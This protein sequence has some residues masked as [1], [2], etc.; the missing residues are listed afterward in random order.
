[1]PETVEFET[2]AGIVPSGGYSAGSRK[3]DQA[4]YQEYL[5]PLVANTI[6]GNMIRAAQV[7]LGTELGSPRIA[8]WGYEPDLYGGDLYTHQIPDGGKWMP[9]ITGQTGFWTPDAFAAQPDAGTRL[10][11]DLISLFYEVEA[12]TN[13]PI[14]VEHTYVAQE[15]T[16]AASY[17]FDNLPQRIVDKSLPRQL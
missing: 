6:A 14:N 7:R 16:G 17:R 4:F 13:V 1:M 8:A 9:P 5:R 15:E 11:W 2:L 10:F 3:L 12:P